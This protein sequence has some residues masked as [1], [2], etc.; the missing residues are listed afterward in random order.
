M[1]APFPSS[2]PKRRIGKIISLSLFSIFVGVLLLFL[3]LFFRNIWILRYGDTT[4]QQKLADQFSSN[5]TTD[6]HLAELQAAS[7]FD[8]DITKYVRATNP[9]FGDP[10]APLTILAFIDFQCPFTQKAYPT[11][12]EIRKKY[13]P[14]ARLVV[15]QFPLE[16]IHP[17]AKKAALASAC[18]FKEG[19]FWDYYHTL[20]QN[21]DLD[22]TA[23]QAYAVS[24]GIREE[25]FLNCYTHETPIKEIEQDM[26]DGIDLGVRGTPTYFI[27]N[28]KV[29]GA[30]STQ[31]WDELI[32]KAI[33]NK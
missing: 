1:P 17:Q 20:F 13:A 32:L 25:N 5:F 31:T 28:I 22:E 30:I 27:N 9:Q 3:L 4:A 7:T 10:K 21:R 23:I 18:A 16:A 12:E 26:Q 6:P 2:T 29:E 11:L 24:T 19:K 14:V 8:G 33:N 15:K